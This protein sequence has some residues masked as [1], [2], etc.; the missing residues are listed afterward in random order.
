MFV[1]LLEW[2]NRLYLFRNKQF[3]LKRNVDINIHLKYTWD[4]M[5]NNLDVNIHLK[6]TWDE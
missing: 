3:N 5:D 1:L 2:N 6:Y 4:G